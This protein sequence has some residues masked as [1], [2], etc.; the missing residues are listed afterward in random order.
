[1][2]VHLVLLDEIKQQ[3][4]GS[5]ENLQADFVIVSFHGS[6]VKG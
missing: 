4:Q 6:G 3:V 2:D 5:F 1:M